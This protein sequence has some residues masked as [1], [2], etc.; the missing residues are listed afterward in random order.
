MTIKELKEIMIKLNKKTLI[1]FTTIPIKL[2]HEL[3]DCWNDKDITIDEIPNIREENIVENGHLCKGIQCQVIGND[4]LDY[5]IAENKDKLQHILDGYKGD[6]SESILNLTI[7]NPNEA[8]INFYAIEC[9]I[10]TDEDCF[11]I[12]DHHLDELD[13]LKKENNK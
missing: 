8:V 3:H 6:I 10:E 11:E 12:W 2:P 7:F 9:T 1:C 4:K 13:K 5:I